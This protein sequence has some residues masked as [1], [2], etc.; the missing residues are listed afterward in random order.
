MRRLWWT[1]CRPGSG[2]GYGAGRK[3]VACRA[4]GQGLA[5]ASGDWKVRFRNRGCGADLLTLWGHTGGVMSVAFSAD[6]QRLA[7]ASHDRTV[8]LWDARSGAELLTL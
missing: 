6:G 2:S 4:D 1:T 7:S 3:V 8:K 5:A